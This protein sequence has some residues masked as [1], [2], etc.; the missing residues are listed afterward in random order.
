MHAIIGTTKINVLLE[1][2]RAPGD[3]KVH[4]WCIP[5]FLQCRILDAIHLAESHIVSDG[6]TDIQDV[7]FLIQYNEETINCLLV[8]VTMSVWQACVN[9]LM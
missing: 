1:P 6:F 3:S 4:P 9:V 2:Q 5:N 8:T 7:G